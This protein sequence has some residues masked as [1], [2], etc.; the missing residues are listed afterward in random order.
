MSLQQTAVLA[1]GGGGQRKAPEISKVVGRALLWN[2]N[3]RQLMGG[4]GGAPCRAG[5]ELLVVV[6]GSAGKLGR[7]QI[8]LR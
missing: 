3:P 8:S 6:T 4:A 2:F 7:E 5:G 1:Y